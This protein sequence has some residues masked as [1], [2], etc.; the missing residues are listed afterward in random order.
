M[1][2]IH[3]PTRSAD[4]VVRA[5]VD[6]MLADVTASRQVRAVLE[7]VALALRAEHPSDWESRL[8]KLWSLALRAGEVWSPKDG[9]R[10]LDRM[11]AALAEPEQPDTSMSPA[12]HLEALAAA[13]G[14]RPIDDPASL[15]FEDWPEDESADDFIAAVR[16]SR[17]EAPPT[18]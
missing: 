12:Q 1:S 13:Q 16:E 7:R 10:G 8:R 2:T 15:V 17:R 3:D 4:P 14:V 5:A 6:A 11:L 18:A 9:M